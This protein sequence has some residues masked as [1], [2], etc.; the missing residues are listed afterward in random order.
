MYPKQREAVSLTDG[1]H[2]LSTSH[3]RRENVTLHSHTKRKRD[4]IEQ[5]H[6]R[7][8]GRSSLARQNTCLHRRAVGN[9][10][11]RVD[12]LLELLAVEEVTEE[13]LDARNTGRTTNKDDLVNLALVKARVLQHLLNRLD[14]AVESLAV[15]VLETRAGDV[16]V[17]VLA[18]EERVN[19]DRGL[20]AVRQS[21]LGALTGCPQTAESTCVTRDVLF[22]S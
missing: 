14:G 11:I 2:S 4:D 16:G 17:E 3:N 10:L 18:V 22:S 15:D 20:C 21:T 6:V 12:A 5:K 8:I 13:L 1:R 19:L 9:S 7:S